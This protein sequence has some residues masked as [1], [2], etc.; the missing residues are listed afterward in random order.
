MFK[1]EDIVM[2]VGF[3]AT[4]VGLWTGFS[5]KIAAQEKRLTTLEMYA[6]SNKDKLSE[7]ARR[8]ENH[9]QEYRVMVALVEKVDNLSKDIQEIKEDLKKGVG[10]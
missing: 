10:E 8:L 6:A 1:P 2:I 7:H 4:L 3:I 9:E 5:G